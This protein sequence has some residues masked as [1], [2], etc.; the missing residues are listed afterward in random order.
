MPATEVAVADGLHHE[1]LANYCPNVVSR[2]ASLIASIF[3]LLTLVETPPSPRIRISMFFHAL[4][5]PIDFGWCLI[6]KLA[7]WTECYNLTSEFVRQGRLA[8]EHSPR[9]RVIATIIVGFDEIAGQRQSSH[10]SFLEV[11]EQYGT[12]NTKSFIL[13]RLIALELADHWKHGVS[14]ALPFTVF[15][16]LQLLGAM[17]IK[18]ELH[19]TPFAAVLLSW[20]IPLALLSGR[21][22]AFRSP[23]ACLDTISRFVEEFTAEDAMLKHRT[24]DNS[25]R[26]RRHDI[27]RV[28]S[29]IYAEHHP[30]LDGYRPWKARRV[31]G[32]QLPTAL[33]TAFI[34]SL[35][36]ILSIATFVS[37]LWI[38]GPDRT[39]HQWFLAPVV[40]VLWVLST[41]LSQGVYCR[42][43]NRYQW[44]AIVAKD[45]VI[46]TIIV[47][48]I[49][50]LST[51]GRTN[52][53]S[54]SGTGSGPG[55]G[56]EFG[57]TKDVL[58]EHGGVHN[59]E[60]TSVLALCS[61][62]QLCFYAAV[63]RHYRAGLMIM[64]WP[65]ETRRLE[66]AQLETRK[67]MRAS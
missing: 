42:I 40:S 32:P 7:A 2:I 9:R 26:R 67:T 65:E 51:A 57:T 27:K 28:M 63:V 39:T 44:H 60:Y 54:D 14:T 61:G 48:A 59:I 66:Y 25:T 11:A 52:E 62:S 43:N 30:N 23:R 24:A 58:H 3:L 20:A 55:A 19:C 38:A 18:F 1:P 41:L 36:I 31:N 29:R 35:P 22:G 56:S 5:D 34:A 33:S 21:M 37:L 4:A 49:I 64:Q 16:I 46:A 47:L 13:R 45:M 17:K 53:T 10:Q 6:H 12:T 50:L 15:Y 8:D